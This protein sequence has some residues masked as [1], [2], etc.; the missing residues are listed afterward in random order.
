MSITKVEGEEWG[1]L[2]E[3]VEEWM[4]G[5]SDV[6]E[7]GCENLKRDREAERRRE[8]GGL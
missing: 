2:R 4:R 1:Q 6:R 8:E 7:G 3:R 5:W